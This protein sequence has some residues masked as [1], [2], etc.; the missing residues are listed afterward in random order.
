MALWEGGFSPS[1]CEYYANQVL[2]KATLRRLVQVSLD[3]I[4]MAKQEPQDV[5]KLIDQAEQMVLSVAERRLRPAGTSIGDLSAQCYDV[6]ER[7]AETKTTMIGV[8]TG[9]SDFDRIVKGLKPQEI[10]I[11][12]ARPSMG[13]SSIV[14]GVGMHA[15]QKRDVPVL[16]VSIEM[17][18]HPVARRIISA[19]TGIESDRLKTGDLSEDEWTQ[20]FNAC[21]DLQSVPLHVDDVSA[22][23][24]AIKGSLRRFKR[25]H[26]K[27]GLLIVDYLQ[28]MEYEGRNN[29]T[30]RERV[31]RT[32]KALKRVAKQMDTHVILLSQLT[33]EA[34]GKEPTLNMLMESG[35]IEAAAD[36]VVFLHRERH[37]A[38]GEVPSLIPTEII[39][40]KHRDGATGRLNLGFVPKTSSFTSMEYRL[41]PP[42]EP[43]TKQRKKRDK[44]DYDTRFDGPTGF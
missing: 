18:E 3:I 42:D 20:Y 40:P 24:S 7:N 23:V 41:E 12:A 25:K 26:G 22:S 38:A 39:I 33:R 17:A 35:D 32:V 2:Q 21:A 28:E 30:T 13:K 1:N 14:A 4:E 31:G 43:Q 27:C 8:S 9:Y 19:L 5:E 44:Q 11:W 29:E 37:T 36:L 15:A 16:F 34:E 6:A 10:S